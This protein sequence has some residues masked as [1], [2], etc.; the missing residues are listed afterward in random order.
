MRFLLLTALVLLAPGLTPAVDAQEQVNAQDPSYARVERSLEVFA[1]KFVTR[2]ELRTILISAQ[3]LR[4]VPSPTLAK[5]YAKYLGEYESWSTTAKKSLI[6]TLAQEHRNNRG[7]D[8]ETQAAIIDIW[9]QEQKIERG[10]FEDIRSSAPEDARNRIQ[11]AWATRHAQ[12]WGERCDRVAALVSWAGRIGQIDL[13]ECLTACNEIDF[14]DK[15]MLQQALRYEQKRA[16]MLITLANAGLATTKR[17]RQASRL[18][19]D[20]V[21]KN[22]QE[23][24]QAEVNPQV[25]MGMATAIQMAPLICALNHITTLQKETS[26]SFSASLDPA[27]AW[28]FYA[29][30]IARAMLGTNQVQYRQII[31][32]ARESASSDS[33]SDTERQREIEKF[34]ALDTERILAWL[35]LLSMQLNRQCEMLHPMI[36]MSTVNLDEMA[37]AIQETGA[38]FALKRTPRD[39]LNARFELIQIYVGSLKKTASNLPPPSQLLTNP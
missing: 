28:C 26:E 2:S 30:M 15:Q 9:H 18:A 12:Y 33:D 27:Q 38:T 39:L 13:L 8:E 6:E 11:L 29:E 3:C 37:R 19:Q 36:D 24:P 16:E 32:D 10:L 25:G 17:A 1:P 5:I 20:W 21:V 22:Q 34:Q 7:R 4:V 31:S 35:N 14:N 23:N